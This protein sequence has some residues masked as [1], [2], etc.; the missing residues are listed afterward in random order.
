LLLPLLL[1]IADGAGDGDGEVNKGEKLTY[2]RI[3]EV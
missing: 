3:S 2:K 1:T